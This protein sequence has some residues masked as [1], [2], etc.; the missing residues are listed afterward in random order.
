M[1][2]SLLFRNGDSSFCKIYL[3]VCLLLVGFI[4]LNAQEAPNKKV[5]LDL[6]NVPLIDVLLDIQKQTGVNFAYEKTQVEQFKPVTI[7]IKGATVEE[8]LKI[9]LKDTGFTYK[10]TGNNIAIVKQQ[11]TSTVKLIQVSGKVT[12]EKGN[13]IPGA[14]VII[15]GTTQGVA[16]DVDGRYTLAVKPDDVL[17]VSFVGYKPEVVPIKGKTK[18]NVALNPTAENIE[19]V[20]VVAFGTQKKESVVSAIT[21]VRPMDLKSS[22]SDLTS[23]LAGRVR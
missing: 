10:I 20:Q 11:E 19:E 21:T 8:V 7:S 14:T 15:H 9:I 13:S 12:D 18:V 5:S 1:K 22:S 23:S 2:K 3:L 17:R 4:N 16:T 6:K